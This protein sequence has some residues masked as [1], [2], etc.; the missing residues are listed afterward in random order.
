MRRGR[1]L[2]A[3]VDLGVVGKP[4]AISTLRTPSADERP[5]IPE[6]VQPAVLG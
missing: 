2:Q 3:V 4:A 6:G 5:V 1:L